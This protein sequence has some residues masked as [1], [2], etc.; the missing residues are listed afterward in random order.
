MPVN[1]SWT[2]SSLLLWAPPTAQQV[3]VAIH[4]PRRRV[5]PMKA[6]LNPREGSFRSGQ[7]RPA[8]ARVRE[9]RGSRLSLVARHRGGLHHAAMMR[10]RVRARGEVPVVSFFGG[11]GGGGG[12]VGECPLARPSLSSL[13]GDPRLAK[14]MQLSDARGIATSSLACVG[15]R[16]LKKRRL[17]CDL[18]FPPTPANHDMR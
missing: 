4:Q 5:R 13:L 15:I 9:G 7:V 18:G 11:G 6:H 10:R 8:E 3:L 1:R 14:P 16:P 2:A 17:P 12:G